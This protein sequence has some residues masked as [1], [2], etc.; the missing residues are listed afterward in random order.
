MDEARPLKAADAIQL[1]ASHAPASRRPAGASSGGD[2]RPGK[3]SSACFARNPLISPDS[4]KFFEIF[5]RELQVL[6]APVE[7]K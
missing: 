5:G 2:Q 7:G 3:I 4:R 6:E 1:K